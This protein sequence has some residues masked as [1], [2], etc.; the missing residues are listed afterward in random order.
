[1]KYHTRDLGKVKGMLQAAPFTSILLMVGALALVGSPP[2]NIFI[3]KFSIISAGIASGFVWVM[4]AC[5][6]FLAVVFAAFLRVISSSVFGELP[7]GVSKGEIQTTML[8]PVAVL[9][10]LVV[11]LGLYLPPQVGVLLN[12]AMQEVL[13]NPPIAGA[14][15]LFAGID[16]ASLPVGL[17]QAGQF[18]IP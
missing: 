4:I 15:G 3:S 14:A 6:L 7:E 5:V 12:Q 1:M 17:L 11:L 9:M 13:V 18:L 10:V 8:A 16:S 2:F